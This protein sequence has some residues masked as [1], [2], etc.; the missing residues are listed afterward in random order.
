[1]KSRLELFIAALTDEQAHLLERAILEIANHGET[2]IIFPVE[3][4]NIADDILNY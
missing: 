1:M 3:M 2:T 4:N